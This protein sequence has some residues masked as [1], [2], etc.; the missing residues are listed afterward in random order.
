MAEQKPFPPLSPST[1]RAWGNTL[2]LSGTGQING[3]R[4]HHHPP[5]FHLGL[6][7][8]WAGDPVHHH[9]RAQEEAPR[10]GGGDGTALLER[11]RSRPRSAAGAA[12]GSAP[13]HHLGKGDGGQE[14]HYE[15]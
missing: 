9:R 10:A 2:P 4:T 12:S 6:H 11:C 13:R 1:L 7:F 3:H 15:L 8:G 5:L 14:V